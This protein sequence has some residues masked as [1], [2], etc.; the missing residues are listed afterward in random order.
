MSKSSAGRWWSLTRLEWGVL[1]AIFVCLIL[2]L[3]PGG[4][5]A[6][7]GEIVVPVRVIVFD[8][9]R[10]SMRREGANFAGGS[11]TACRSFVKLQQIIND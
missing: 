1:A 8:A 7:S 6:S 9:E 10:T 11:V 3:W 5:W 2:L 4:K